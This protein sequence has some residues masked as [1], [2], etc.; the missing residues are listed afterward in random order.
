[1]GTAN[2]S[3]PTRIR[4]KPTDNSTMCGLLVAVLTTVSSPV[5]R[6]WTLAVTRRAIDHRAP[7]G[8]GAISEQF[9]T[10]VVTTEKSPV[11]VKLFT[12]TGPTP[13]LRT[14]TNCVALG[15]P[16]CTLDHGSTRSMP[17]RVRC[18]T[19]IENE[20]LSYIEQADGP[21][22]SRRVARWPCTW[23]AFPPR[24]L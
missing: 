23:R 17:T 22:V 9:A 18:V 24:D 14:V 10:P 2:S 16:T 15:V 6:P 5:R 12:C 21:G 19:T 8:S 1:M 3:S 20:F 7:A 13:V 11:A 4:R